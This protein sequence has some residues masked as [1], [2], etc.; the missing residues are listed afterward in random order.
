MLLIKYGNTLKLFALKI[1]KSTNYSNSS[2]ST[3]RLFQ[4]NLDFEFLS[5][6]NQ[7]QVRNDDR[8]GDFF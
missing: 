7:T 4:H 8:R 6:L 2:K 1:K 5:N 3:F